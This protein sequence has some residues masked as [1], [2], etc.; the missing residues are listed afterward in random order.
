[1]TASKPEVKRWHPENTAFG[2]NMK[3]T[4]DGDFVLFCHH[5]AAR[6]ADKARIKLL[7]EQRDAFTMHKL[8]SRQCIGI[9]ASVGVCEPVEGFAER[10]QDLAPA[11][12][13]MALIIEADKARIAE[14]EKALMEAK[15]HIT[16]GP[17]GAHPALE[18][19]ARIDAALAQ[20][21]KEGEK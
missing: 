5:E 9:P 16:S 11:M 15:Q 14:L 7:E 21:G 1:M 17:Y 4:P 12:R 19:I 13:E 10:P 8:A 3:P 6:A 2:Y 18:T 20:Q